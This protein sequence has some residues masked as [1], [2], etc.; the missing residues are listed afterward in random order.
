MR[1]PFL[2]KIYSHAQ[3]KKDAQ[4]KEFFAEIRF[5]IGRARLFLMPLS[6]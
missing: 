6:P 4:Q 1:Q 5:G 2:K 3:Q